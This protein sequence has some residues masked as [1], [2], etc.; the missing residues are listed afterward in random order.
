MGGGASKKAGPA[1]ASTAIKEAR[2]KAQQL[3][4][5][6]EKIEQEKRE[7]QKALQDRL[8]DIEALGEINRQLQRAN[9]KL[10]EEAKKAV[11]CLSCSFCVGNS[12]T[13]CFSF[14]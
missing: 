10:K 7:Q 3:E 11:S 13:Y 1:P 2:A 5:E 12:Y 6:L 8:N 4:K 14:L 9:E